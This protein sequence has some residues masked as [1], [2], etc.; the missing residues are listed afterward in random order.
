MVIE[1]ILYFDFVM[2]SN[3]FGKFNINRLNKFNKFN[4]FEKST[5]MID[6]F[7]I[8]QNMQLYNFSTIINFERE[9]NKF[10]KKLNHVI[11]QKKYLSMD[12]GTFFLVGLCTYIGYYCMEGYY[13]VEKEKISSTNKL[14]IAKLEN[15]KKELE[16]KNVIKIVLDKTDMSTLA[17][18]DSGCFTKN[19]NGIEVIISVVPTT[20]KELL[21]NKNSEN[22]K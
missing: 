9:K 12:S 10:S 14:E 1:I 20:N 15:A 4:N 13:I 2:L 19:I 18:T 21:S 22:T 6:N 5:N 16:N 7:K 17:G 11:N 3:R 8:A